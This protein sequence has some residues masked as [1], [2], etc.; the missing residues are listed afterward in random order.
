[1]PPKAQ[2]TTAAQ[3]SSS[4][5]PQP[6]DKRALDKHSRDRLNQ[7]LQ[8]VPSLKDED[9]HSWLTTVKSCAKYQDW[10]PHILDIKEN[11]PTGHELTEEIKAEEKNALFL[12]ES[13]TAGTPAQH[14]LEGIPQNKKSDTQYAYQ[15]LDEYYHPNTIAGKGKILD[16]FWNLSQER[17][18]LSLIQYTAEVSRRAHRAKSAGSAISEEQMVSKLLTGLSKDFASIQDILMARE[19]SLTFAE[20]TR[21]LIAWAE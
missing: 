8:L 5:Q 11:R 10:P 15:R 12:L 20:A 7:L 13:K 18:N 1:M 16:Q 3:V 6:T 19:E 2:N 17:A 9:Y 21:L 4:A 14:F